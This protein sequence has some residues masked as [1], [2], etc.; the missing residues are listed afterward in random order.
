MSGRRAVGVGWH[1]TGCGKAPTVASGCPSGFLSMPP[2]PDVE[3][4][5]PAVVDVEPAAGELEWGAWPAGVRDCAEEVEIL[6]QRRCTPLTGR[7]PIKVRAHMDRQWICRQ[8]MSVLI[9]TNNEQVT[10]QC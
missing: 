2:D 7:Q 4:M 8:S 5:W 1:A 6:D 3:R 9:V 10:G